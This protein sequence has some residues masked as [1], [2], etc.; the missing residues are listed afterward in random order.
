MKVTLNR[1]QLDAI[2][3]YSKLY[4]HL[5]SAFTKSY[6]ALGDNK[7]IIFFQGVKG[8]LKTTIAVECSEATQYFQSDF[9]KLSNALS[10]VGFD[11][12]VTLSLTEKQLRVLL[13]SSGDTIN[14]AI[15]KYLPTSAEAQTI[16]N[17]VESITQRVRDE[18]TSLLVTE[19]L[20][21]AFSIA[22]AMFSS[23]GRNNAVAVRRSYVMYAD[24]S[25]V[26]KA[27]L[28]EPLD[29]SVDTIELH[30]FTLSTI[31]AAQKSNPF[32]QFSS[33]YSTLA[34]SDGNTT[35]F[36]LATEAIEIAIP[37]DD[38]IANIVP[39]DGAV[40]V[41]DHRALQQG[42]NFFNGFYEATVWKP[43]TFKI[44][45]TGEALLYYKHPS[46]E[47]S[48]SLM[49]SGTAPGEFIVASETIA[50]LV[51]KSVELSTDNIPV[52]FIYDD[53]APG[54]SCKI[55]SLYDV[56]LAKLVE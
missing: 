48:K 21:N 54:V 7:F 18:N 28:A 1:A 37:S 36:V 41:V 56:I 52:T 31:I 45:A 8:A 14:L 22:A 38:D 3:Q 13:P 29:I 2:Q 25:I 16:Q 42:L 9:A 19:E 43:I 32:F 44:A 5:S 50:K 40:L 4:S 49:A 6:F 47:I 10:K 27:M 46:T 20:L 53:D 24:R 33:D 51:S 55:G 11:N 39:T 23:V 34:W 30:K 35:S 17:F 15:L 26:L 12:E